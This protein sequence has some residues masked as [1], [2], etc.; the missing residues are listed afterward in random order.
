MPKIALI[1]AFSLPYDFAPQNRLQAAIW[2]NRDFSL[3]VD[4]SI[5][6]CETT[7]FHGQINSMVEMRVFSCFFLGH[8]IGKLMKIAV[9]TKNSCFCYVK[10]GVG[11]GYPQNCLKNHSYG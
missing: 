9:V 4:P 2:Q 6:N 11:L 1:L 8:L 7:L 10:K 5:Y 3:S